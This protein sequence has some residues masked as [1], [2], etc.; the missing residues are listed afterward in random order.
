MT[1]YKYIGKFFGDVSR[2]DKVFKRL[3]LLN[4]SYP[5]SNINC[6][7]VQILRQLQNQERETIQNSIRD[8]VIK[9]SA[10]FFGPELSNYI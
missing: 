6:S 7:Q 4:S 5:L 8:S 3:N 10:V 9:E 2:W 1:S